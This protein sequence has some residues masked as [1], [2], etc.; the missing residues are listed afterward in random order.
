MR[1]NLEQHFLASGSRGFAYPS[2]VAGGDNAC[3]LHYTANN[4]PLNDGDLLLIDAGCSVSDYYNGDITRTFPIN[5]RFSPEQRDLY[6]LVR[7]RRR[8]YQVSPGS[9]A[10]ACMRP[11]CVCWWRVC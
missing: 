3:I 2:I 11:R 5:G 6:S 1:A 4:A 8:P 10:E 7:P 9:T